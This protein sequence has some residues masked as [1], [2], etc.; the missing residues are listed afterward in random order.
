MTQA[1]LRPSKV[2]EKEPRKNTG[3]QKKHFLAVRRNGTTYKVNTKDQDDPKYFHLWNNLD[4][5]K[6][7]KVA[8]C[9]HTNANT[10]TT[11][12]EHGIKGYRNI[13]P[14]GGV[15]GTYV[16]PSPIYLRFKPSDH[17][18]NDDTKITKLTLS[19][20]HRCTTANV[21]NNTEY[22]GVA[23]NFSGFDVY[24]SN[25]VL[26][27]TFNGVS[28]TSNK[29]PPLSLTKYNTVSF[30]FSFPKGITGKT[31]KD[32]VMTVAYGHNLEADA[33]VLYVDDFL[34]TVDY[35]GKKEFFEAKQNDSIVY[36]AEDSDC[37]STMTYTLK[38]GFKEGTK[39]VPPYNQQSNIK[40]S[41]PKGVSVVMENQ[42]DGITVIA[43]VKDNSL[44]AGKKQIYFSLGKNKKEFTFTSIIRK[45]PDIKMLSQIEKNTV[46][47]SP[48]ILVN[49][50]CTKKITAYMD[51][52]GGPSF[53][54]NDI[55]LDAPNMI[56]QTDI[57]SFYNFLEGQ[58]CGN[59]T[60]YF[61]RGNETAETMIVKSLQIV[62]TEYNVQAYYNGNEVTGKI[63]DLTQNKE[64][65]DKITLKYIKGLKQ[66]KNPPEFLIINPTYG[67]IPAG[68]N[69]PTRYRISETG[70]VWKTS[71]SDTIEIDIGTY[72]PGEYTIEIREP[73]NC[74]KK[75]IS[76]D[77]QINS[78]HEQ[79]FGSIFVRGEDSTA[80][81]Y[82]YLVALEGDTIQEPIY[83][84]S[85]VLGA[86]YQD[87]S[88]CVAKTDYIARIGD[89]EVVTL[90]VTNN[91]E[92]N[93]RNLYLE[94]NLLKKDEDE[95]YYVSTDDWVENG[96]IFFNLQNDFYSYNE[97]ISNIVEILNLTK[98]ADEIDEENVYINIKELPANKTIPINIPYNSFVEQETYM[99]ILLFEEPMEISLCSDSN[100]K[101]D[102]IH[103][104]VFD[105]ILTE[106]SIKGDTD[107]LFP[108]KNCP[109]ECFKTE[110]GIR[111]L[112]KNVDSSNVDGDALFIIENDP[113]L[114]PYKIKYKKKT[115]EI[116]N[117]EVI[118]QNDNPGVMLGFY[119][120]EERLFNDKISFNMIQK[121]ERFF[122]VESDKNTPFLSISVPKEING[123]I[124]IWDYNDE[125][126]I[127]FE[128]TF[129]EIT[130]KIIDE[131]PS[132]PDV[133]QISFNDFGETLNDF[134]D[135]EYFIVDCFDTDESQSIKTT[136]YEITKDDGT[137]TFPV[138]IKNQITEKAQNY[139]GIK[140]TCNIDFGTFY[141]K[142]TLVS[143]T[144]ANS[145]ATFF[146]KIPVEIG[147]QFTVN[148]LLSKGICKFTGDGEISVL[149]NDYIYY[150]P[151]QNIPIQ[152]KAVKTV[153]YIENK[154]IFKADIIDSGS[155]DYLD[156]YY[157]ICNLPNNEGQLKT[158]FKTK[159]DEGEYNLVP[160]E[161]S[162]TIL[163]GTQTDITPFV[164]LKEVVIENKHINRL[165]ISLNNKK[166]FNKDI[167]VTI[168]ENNNDNL[169][170]YKYSSHNID[171]GELSI[172]NDKM[173]WNI[174]YLEKDSI[175]TG[176]IDFEAQNIGLSNL[177]VEVK[178]FLS[179]IDKSLFDVQCEC[180]K[181]Q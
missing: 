82:D 110:N 113:R 39:I 76:I 168:S 65:N 173:V 28:K 99:Q 179:D 38:A 104:R 64:E 55:Q 85:T 41:A 134:I 37:A 147:E 150:S 57:E 45:K 40:Y 84:A 12:T 130:N 66:L 44:I 116:V 14:I 97:D 174:S 100:Q 62:P 54:F 115:G 158:V 126:K 27:V 181:Q 35:V 25:K 15:T 145:V 175:V 3:L 106:M 52:I 94:L 32:K 70:T 148:S 50:G 63:K 78:H 17:G 34:L 172:Q 165:Y 159:T 112:V 68:T 160:N 111:Y 11:K 132:N 2:T 72:Y 136:L 13:C 163:C 109:Y 86:S 162:E 8:Q 46:M 125:E 107:I 95:K 133:Y 91:S 128:K 80:F 161:I 131:N 29:N 151:G 90:Q 30:E 137:Y 61:Q 51:K 101:F 103:L 167:S 164:S 93:I 157:N 1:V 10:C 6:Y 121:D 23:P 75:N 7:G 81:D 171:T 67:L 123:K 43:K 144:D 176:Y 180:R 92:R 98:D 47:T 155:V 59:H 69:T 73:N 170:K 169:D 87:I 152:V 42:S 48:S 166:R 74:D 89:T 178:D 146:I 96:G 129:S 102:K 58:S 139:R 120:Y 26:T 19:F 88:L 33:A 122:H 20:K 71:E 22:I 9:G 60:V 5:L 21:A 4:N 143:Y 53:V 49:N 177:K 108:D 127:F 31:L 156:V 142:E 117:N 36:T 24:P 138:E 114:K 124:K 118:Y 105:S 153:S 135:T 83:P 79:S 77:V 16:Q 141:P 119:N 56:K 149:G 18:I 154:I 140:V